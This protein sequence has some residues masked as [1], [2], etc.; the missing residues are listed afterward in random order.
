MTLFSIKPIGL[1]CQPRS[2]Q[3]GEFPQNHIMMFHLWCSS[4]NIIDD[5]IQ[6]KIFQHTLTSV[7]DK[8]YI[9]LPQ[10]KYRDFNSLAFMFLQYF[11]LPVR[12]DEGVEILLSFHQNTATHII[13]HIHEW[14]PLRS[15]CKIKLDDRIFLDWFLKKL[16]PPIAKEV[17]S[18][19][20]QIEKEA[21]LKAQ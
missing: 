4:N 9:D 13:D 11:Q 16:I 6:L 1:P 15:L 7:E 10:A 19:C 12:Y 21:I 18:E 5:S 3:T 8:W 2:P 17:T 20:P 14:R